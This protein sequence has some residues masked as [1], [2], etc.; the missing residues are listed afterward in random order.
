MEEASCFLPPQSVS[1]SGAGKAVAGPP[2]YPLFAV[3]L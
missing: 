2:S 1:P 3:A